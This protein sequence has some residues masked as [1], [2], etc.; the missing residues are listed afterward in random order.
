MGEALKATGDPLNIRNITNIRCTVDP[1]FWDA[2]TGYLG[3]WPKAQRNQ[4]GIARF[5]LMEL[6]AS[7][8]G[9]P[10]P[11]FLEP[12]EAPIGTFSVQVRTDDEQEAEDWNFLVQ[13]YGGGA[14]A[15][16]VALQALFH[17][18][19]DGAARLPIET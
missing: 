2:L 7:L 9:D 1:I 11:D 3:N 8:K 10:D 6:Y 14:P 15:L 19:E 18:F 5:A 13:R 4:S 16:R 17:Y 12:Y